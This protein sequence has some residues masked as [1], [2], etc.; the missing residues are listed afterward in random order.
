MSCNRPC[1]C[2]YKWGKGATGA[3]GATGSS[4]ATGPSGGTGATGATGPSSPNVGAMIS[5][6]ADQIQSIENTIPTPIDFSTA[7]VEYAN[8]VTVNPDSFTIE[9]S[10]SYLFIV[11]ISWASNSNGMRFLLVQRNGIDAYITTTPAITGAATVVNYS[12]FLNLD[13]G[14]TL[15]FT[16][17]QQSG[18]VLNIVAFTTVAIQLLHPL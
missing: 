17:I 1:G 10:G 18:G 2:H 11:N 13:V 4:G 14:D 5:F 8:D 3:T 6:S 15:T 12:G 16:V 7:I 9:Q